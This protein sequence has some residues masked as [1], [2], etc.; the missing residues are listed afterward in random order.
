MAD[1]GLAAIVDPSMEEMRSMDGYITFCIN[2]T[3]EICSIYK[4]GFVGVPHD[5]II[6]CIRVVRG[7]MTFLH[8]SLSREI[9]M[10]DEREKSKYNEKIKKEQHFNSKMGNLVQST[11]SSDISE[12][13]DFNNLHKAAQSV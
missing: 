4:P 11:S 12:L 2:A 10:L 13:T 8:Q 1:S 3:D 6:K 7:R 9:S 5:V